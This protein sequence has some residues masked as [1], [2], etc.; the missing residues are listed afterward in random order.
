MT[1]LHMHTVFCDGVNTPEEM[2]LSAIDKGLSAVG[3]CTHAYLPFD[4]EFCIQRENYSVFQ[5]EVAGLK[6]KYRDRIEVLCG[7]EQDILCT[8][9]TE[10]FDYVIGAVHCLDCGGDIIPVDNT[11]ELLAEG[12]RRQFGGD[13][14]AL[15]EAY[16]ESVARIYELTS[17][18][19]IAHFDLVTKFNEGGRLF[20]ESDPRYI[21]AS[22][23]AADELLKCGRPFE[24]NTGAMSRGYRTSPYPAKP[25]MDYI[26]S[27][28]GRFVL[29]SDAHHKEN[30]AYRFECYE[31]LL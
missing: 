31:A 9:N 3:I 28:G 21:A 1:D 8:E 12:C 29:A 4:K 18:D 10:G 2:V 7:I 13:Y 25:I 11:P 20:D 5:N 14:I 24:I 27:R 22:R 16:Y 6:E 23:R 15:C 17:C 19:S 30:I 26:R